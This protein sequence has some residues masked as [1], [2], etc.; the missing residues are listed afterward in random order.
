MVRDYWMGQR[1]EKDKA[2]EAYWETSLHDGVLAGTAFPAI[3]VSAHAGC[4]RRRHRARGGD[5]I[6]IVFKPDPA[7]F[8]GRFANN[9]WLQELPKPNTKLTWDNA[10][11]ISPQTAQKLGLKDGNYVKL[12][13]GRREVKAGVV[14]VPGHADNSI[15]LHLGY[16]RRKAGRWEPGR[17]STR[18]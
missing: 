10:A 15:T 18:I 2:Y 3:S 14:L 4:G 11:M 9:G 5:D 13:L 6:E 17:D 16:G 7:V 8:D 1:T 12:Q